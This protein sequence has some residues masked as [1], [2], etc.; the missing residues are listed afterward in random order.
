MVRKTDFDILM[1]LTP[2]EEEADIASPQLETLAQYDKRFKAQKSRNSHPK[3]HSQRD[4]KK[5][6][7]KRHS[8]RDSHHKSES[9]KNAR[10]AHTQNPN[11]IPSF[12][13]H[14][15]EV[16]NY[17]KHL[18]TKRECTKRPSRYSMEFIR[19]AVTHYNRHKRDYIRINP[20]VN[21]DMDYEKFN[22]VVK[23]YR[24]WYDKSRH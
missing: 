19:C 18:D 21:D 20:R 10:H 14:V 13:D 23:R 15:N 9:R 16:V 8:K 22:Q 4:S 11:R 1:D 3:R 24:A 2:D 6:D 17:I 7:S 12:N 5:R